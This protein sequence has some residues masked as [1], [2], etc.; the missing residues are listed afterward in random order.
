MRVQNQPYALGTIR[1]SELVFEG[2]PQYSHP[3]IGSMADLESAKFE[4]VKA[5]HAAHYA[6]NRAVLTIA[7]DFDA[8]RALALVQKYF[9]PAERTSE[10]PTELAPA[11]AEPNAG[12]ALVSDDN[13]RTPAV[14]LGF[15]IPR[16][17]TPEHY[18]LELAAMIL[19]DGE[20]SRLYRSLVHD[21]AVA[22]SVSAWTDEH[23]GPDQLTVMA[24]LT[25]KARPPEVEAKLDAALGRLAK[26]RP[27]ADELARAKRRVMTSFLTGLETNLSRAIRLGEYETLYG[28][29][30]LLPEELGGY[31]AV[32]AEDVRNAVARYL[33]PA[34]RSIVEIEPSP[35]G[36]P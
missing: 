33:T 9:A 20:T 1:L 32:T 16:S 28:N 10:P 18:A 2:Y 14:L 23:R 7:G 3:T 34:R 17:R 31:V 4:W 15:L 5:F 19:A 26:T 12:E 27:S 21:R 22:S 6:P 36:A 35:Q 13:T 29:A 30:Q 25:D 11:P 8:E 24:V